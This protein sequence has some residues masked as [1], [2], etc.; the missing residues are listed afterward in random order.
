MYLMGALA[1]EGQKAINEEMNVSLGHSPGY[2]FY[3]QRRL[4]LESAMN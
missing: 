4:W 1:A 2:E 3:H